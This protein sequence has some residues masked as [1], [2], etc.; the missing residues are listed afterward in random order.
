MI[1]AL[2]SVLGPSLEE[3]IATLAERVEKLATCRQTGAELKTEADKLAEKFGSDAL[4]DE[5]DGAAVEQLVGI[6][7]KIVLNERALR[8]AERDARAK[9]A[10]VRP[11]VFDAYRRAKQLAADTL[12]NA[13]DITRRQLAAQFDAEHVE[14]VLHWVRLVRKAGALADRLPTCNLGDPTSKE[15]EDGLDPQHV[16]DTYRAIAG[17]VAEVESFAARMAERRDGS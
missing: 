13:R 3:Q 12:A 11:A 9:A 1:A 14:L 16:L 7:T 15:L 10:A 5:P 4:G 17:F 8:G 2:K 6:N